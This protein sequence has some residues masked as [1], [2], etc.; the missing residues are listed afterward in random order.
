MV[1]YTILVRYWTPSAKVAQVRSTVPDVQH[2]TE[3]WQ[4]RRQRRTFA[5]NAGQIL[6]PW[7]ALPRKDLRV[8]QLALSC[9]WHKL[10]IHSGTCNV[11]VHHKHSITS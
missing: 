1:S 8:L 4:F 6:V 3:R 10:L 11:A 2:S 5:L 7:S 9:C